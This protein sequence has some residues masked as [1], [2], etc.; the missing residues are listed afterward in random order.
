VII[1]E[2]IN[3]TGKKKCKEALLIGNM[4]FVLDEAASQIERGAHILDVNVGLPGIDEGGTMALAVSLLQ[5]TFPV[6]LQI[7]SSEPAVIERTLRYYNGKALVNSVNG[8]QETMDAVFPLI[9]KYGGAV[10][11]LTLDE[12]GIPPTVA[13]RF[14]IA[15]RIISE[16]AK[17]GISPADILIDTL[18]LTV[19]SQQ[20]EALETLKA[21]ALIKEKYG[22][23]GVKTVLGVSNI[24]F[25]LPRREIVNSR[26][27]AM[28]LYAGLDACIINPLSGD[29][30]QTYHAYR[31]LAGF[32][33]NCGS[34]IE[35][36]AD[37]VAANELVRPASVPSAAA[38][39]ADL[40]QIIIKGY[41]DRAG[42]ATRDLLKTL[43]PLD[44]INTYIVPALDVV[45][46][47]FESGRF[48]LPQL[49]LSADTVSC[50]FEEIKAAFAASGETRKSA[51]T[52]ALATVYGDI[53]DI[54]K[55]IVK[56]LLEN[57]GY[58]VIDLGK[59][60]SAET[61]IETVITQHVKLVGLSALMTTTVAN[62]E[63]TIAALKA[64]AAA[65]GETCVIMAG[66][67]VLTAEYAKKI[68]ADYYAKDAL[69]AIAIAKEV[70]A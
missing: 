62:M 63:K 1:G 5:K 42:E 11:A 44:V 41:K 18:T 33:K 36:Y 4:Q 37:T 60:V 12:T 22:A 26:F 68:G 61:I 64:A 34:Y 70:F 13:G 30:L 23:K 38:E 59:N 9:K 27:F 51:G 24:S 8:K 17:Y 10:V 69:A 55:N 16:A 54:G 57:Y 2:R 21:I 47:E 6:P 66:G 14:A 56:A 45:G 29:M 35:H 67:A 48:F 43:A 28:A 25:G 53:H 40:R 58:T 20:D 52:I 32:D 46:A 50:A 31:A 65:N 39:A 19:S 7:D 15:E 3:P 49:L